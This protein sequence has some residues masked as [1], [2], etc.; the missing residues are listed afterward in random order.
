[1]TDD[2]FLERLRAHA[3]SQRAVPP[4]PPAQPDVPPP[5][6]TAEAPRRA[7]IDTPS[8]APDGVA[9]GQL[10]FWQ[11]PIATTAL[12]QRITGDAALAPEV[13]FARRYAARIPAPF[14]L[15]LSAGDPRL[16]RAL[17]EEGACARVVGLDADQDRVDAANRRLA[18][19]LRGRIE[20]RRGTLADWM[21]DAPVG[22]ILARSVL[23]RQAELETVLD[24]IRGHLEPGGLVFVDDFVGPARFQWTDAQLA[25][26]N[27][28][29]ACLPPELLT[30]LTQSDAR[31]KRRVERPDAT[32]FAAAHPRDAVRSDEILAGLDER[33]ERVELR[34]Y[35][36][37]VYHQLFSRIMGNFAP[38]PELVRLLM[39]VDALLTEAGAVAS[40]YV[41]GV[42][43][44]A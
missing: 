39:E 4:A 29:L 43:R 23:H 17:I 40:D 35:G 14:A 37:A 44:R 1:M 22:A 24:A 38:R 11:S 19:G 21:P 7:P 12:R 41:W 34:P 33:F 18:A 13:Y 3:L 30:D 28:L 5:T 9:P 10:S 31:P 15:S 25:I 2:P 42:W 27:R 8:P 26:V 6:P 16:E 36:G 20:F 32:A